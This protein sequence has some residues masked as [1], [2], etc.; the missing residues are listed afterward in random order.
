[1]TAKFHR[2]DFESICSHSRE[3]KTLSYSCINM[4]TLF[5]TLLYG[6]NRFSEG[7]N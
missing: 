6:K 4:V 3:G 1:M 2:T 5:D 7:K